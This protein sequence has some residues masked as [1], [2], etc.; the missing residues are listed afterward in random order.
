MNCE[1]KTGR[2]YGLVALKCKHPARYLVIAPG[3]PRVV[4]GVHARA[5]TKNGL[6]PLAAL[7]PKFNIETWPD[8]NTFLKTMRELGAKVTVGQVEAHPSILIEFTRVDRS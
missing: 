7:G 6:L 8:I 5:Y 4:C 2:P 3:A 1:A